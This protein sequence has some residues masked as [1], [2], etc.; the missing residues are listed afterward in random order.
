MPTRDTKPSE[1]DEDLD[2]DDDEDMDLDEDKDDDD[3]D[4]DDDHDGDKDHDGPRGKTAKGVGDEV[5]VVSGDD[6]METVRAGAAEGAYQA[7]MDNREELVKSILEDA[8]FVNKLRGVVGGQ[9]R[10]SFA[11][12]E[13]KFTDLAARLDKAV[14]GLD[15]IS[16]SLSGAATLTKG[17][18]DADDASA[19]TTP[20]TKTVSE[21]VLTKSVGVDDPP[22]PTEDVAALIAQAKDIQIAKGVRL[23]SLTTILS[24]LSFRRSG[25][26]ITA[27]KSDIARHQS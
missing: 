18:Q 16:K 15:L 20:A 13:A 23:E 6:L 25:E 24:D 27:L 17:V 22:A 21:T 3:K 9:V 26:A 1:K 2:E 12:R 14:D 10:E 4:H 8:E 19:R 11:K 7:T 5:A